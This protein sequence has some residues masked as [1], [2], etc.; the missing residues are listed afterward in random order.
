MKKIVSFYPFINEEFFAPE[1]VTF[2]HQNSIPVVYFDNLTNRTRR[3]IVIQTN[4]DIPENFEL[5]HSV[6]AGGIQLHL[7]GKIVSKKGCDP[8]KE[9]K[10]Y[11]EKANP[12]I[13]DEAPYIPPY[14]P[15]LP[16][17][18]YNPFPQRPY[19]PFSPYPYNPWEVPRDPWHPRRIMLRSGRCCE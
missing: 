9:I 1:N 6:L 18:P 16:Q 7:C 11:I 8:W 10:D 2:S 15:P 13:S 14:T 4:Q 3:Y 12:K 5:L 17:K 19:E